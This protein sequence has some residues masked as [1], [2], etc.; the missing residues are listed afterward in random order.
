MSISLKVR[1]EFILTHEVLYK[2]LVQHV[3]EF[4]FLA[5]WGVTRRH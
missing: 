1:R 2:K 5:R 4:L 3:H